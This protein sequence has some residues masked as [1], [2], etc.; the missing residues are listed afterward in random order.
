M[1]ERQGFEPWVPCGTPLFESGQFN[2]SCI[3]PLL[4]ILTDKAQGV[5]GDFVK[6]N[7]AAN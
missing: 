1:A 6:A 5:G 2:H 4:F 7:M 3:S